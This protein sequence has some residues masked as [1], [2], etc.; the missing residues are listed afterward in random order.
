MIRL[1]ATTDSDSPN[2]RNAG[3]PAKAPGSDRPFRI[4]FSP[5]GKRLAIGYGTRPPS[6]FS[7]GRPS[8]VLAA[9][10]PP[11][12]RRLPTA[13]LKSHGPA[14]AGR[15]SRPAAFMTRKTEPPSSPGIAAA[16]AP[17]GA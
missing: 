7:T 4:A 5:D 15:C 2:F 6:T 8:S 11:M 17:N 10:A 9:R 14:T 12:R 16:S 13:L 3:Q 1:Y